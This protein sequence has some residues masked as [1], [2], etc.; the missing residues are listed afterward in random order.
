MSSD[1]GKAPAIGVGGL[2]FDDA[3]RVLLVCRKY[4]PHAGGWHIPGGRLEAGESLADCCRREVREETGLLIEPGPVLAVADRA[5]EGFQYVIIDLLAELT[6]ASPRE[7]RTGSDAADSRWVAPGQLADY[8]LVEG[9]AAVIRAGQ[10]RRL[11]GAAR[12]LLAAADCPWLYLP[13]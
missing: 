2:V 8:P 7:P 9:L 12:G 3:G 13:E 10:A 5:I 4:P 1:S 11:N 6:A